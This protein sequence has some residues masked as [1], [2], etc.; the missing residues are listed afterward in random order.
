MAISAA[1]LVSGPAEFELEAG[2]HP[3]GELVVVSFEAEE[4]LS[5]P[6][7]VD[8]TLAPRA[9]VEV[10]A[11]ALVGETA[12]LAVS[13]A[14]GQL[15]HFDGIVS[16]VRRW[17]AGPQPHDRRVR[18]VIVPTLARLG[19]VFRSRIFQEK[20]APEIVKQVLSEGGVTDVEDA[21]SGSYAK[22]EYCVQYQET[23]LDFV[24]R[25]L[26]DEGIFYFFR[27]TQGAH[28]LV[29]A[30]APSAHPAIEHGDSTLPFREKGGM[31]VEEHVDELVANVEVLPG[32]VTLRDFDWKKPL[33]DLTAEASAGGADAALEVYEFPGGYAQAQAGTARSKVRME[34]IRARAA[35]FTGASNCRRIQPG[36]TLELS[37]HPVADLDAEYLV[38]AVSHHGQHPELGGHAAAAA[39]AAEGDVYRCR[40][41]LQRKDVPFRPERRTPRPRARGAETAVVVGPSGEEIHTEEN[42]RVKVHFHWDREGALDAHA[43]CWIRVAQA[44][45]GPGFG[46]LYLPRVGHE[47]VV[48]FLGGDPDRPIVTGS[49]YNAANPPPL[50]LPGEKTRSTLRSA[51]TPGANGFNELR[52]EDAAGQEEV[53]VHAQK[54]LSTIV[55]NDR[56]EKIGANDTLTV[57]AD[58]TWR[59]G[60][61]R[62]LTVSGNDTESVAGNETLTVGG[63]KTVT[64]GG[65][66]TE[67]VGG[68]QSVNV[69][70]A[71][72]VTVTL[73]ATETIGL[74][75]ALTVGGAYGVTVGA[76]MNEL[77][78]GVK[79]EEVGGARVE[80]VGA[81]KSETVMGSRSL[82]VGG[83]SSET[84][85]K[86]RSVTIGK[87][88]VVSVSGKLNQAVKAK[89]ELRAK[90]IVLA[91]DDKFTLKVGSAT[92]ELKKNGDVVLKGGKVEVKASGEILLKA[93]KITEN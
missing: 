73:A 1:A 68:S 45:A 85:G 63:S 84:V 25:L 54:D 65:A 81:K 24:H 16:K 86:E 21:L 64:V 55:E 19:H 57:G 83:H 28:T 38:L 93:P 17:D 82:K 31:T 48:E 33:T 4:R 71:Q 14:D 8:V 88:L 11:P 66:H 32:K 30:D 37:E 59:V 12:C 52:F 56:T 49:V 79:A 53:F 50:S 18:L 87:D 44:W 26:E 89:H 6:Y 36:R 2:P 61:S 3:A 51:S 80:V 40:F 29:L 77:V 58:Q 46:A 90:E 5:A 42:G 67:T 22:R 43:S 70:A 60:G 47:V 34:E 23:D 62:A 27:H 75:K 35:R 92:L 69:A 39:N 10:D 7:E 78:G 15:R 13:L 76:A 74:A 20:S 9:G 72:M 41:E 91:A